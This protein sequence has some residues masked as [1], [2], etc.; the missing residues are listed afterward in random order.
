MIDEI[1]AHLEQLAASGII[2]P[3]HSLWASNVVLVRKQDGQLRMCVDYR[4][5]NERTIRDSYALPRIEEILD[6]LSG[7]TFFTVLD[8]KS[9]YHQVDVLEEHNCRTA[10]TVGPL[11]F[12][13]FNCLPFALNNAPVTYQR[14]MGQCLG[15]LNMKICCIYLDDLII[16]LQF[17]RR[18]F[19]M[20]R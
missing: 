3:S 12:W 16:F 6:T 11:G 15:D 20:L 8:M 17:F 7:S 2:R 1:R 5:L 9:G 13:E 10:F 18:T 14:L 4:Q 19:R